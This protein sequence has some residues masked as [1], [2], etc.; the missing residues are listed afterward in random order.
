MLKYYKENGSSCFHEYDGSSGEICFYDKKDN[1]TQH[2]VSYW[3]S[4]VS[5]SEE[6]IKTKDFLNW[7]GYLC[8]SRDS[9]KCPCYHCVTYKS[10]P[11]E[12]CQCPKCS[13]PI[14]GEAYY[15]S[16]NGYCV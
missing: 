15:K 11:D 9:S 16:L 13:D 5:R 8:S 4:G 6:E 14:N 7:E 10:V 1:L 2:T 12:D 3:Y